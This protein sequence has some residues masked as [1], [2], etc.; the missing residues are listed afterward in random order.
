MA[1]ASDP[2][3][4]LASVTELVAYDQVLTL[5]L[6]RAANSVIS[7]PREPVGNVHDAVLRMGAAQVLSFAV[8]AGT[9]PFLDGAVPSYGLSE[10]ALWR[11]SVAAAVA[12]ETLKSFD[13]ALPAD[14]FTA[15][16]LH[17]VG[18]LV[19]DRFINSQTLGYIREAELTGH[20]SRADAELE[21]LNVQHAELGGVIAQHW[22]LP[23]SV[24]AGIAYHHHPAQSR[25]TIADFTWLANQLAKQIEAGVDGRKFAVA[26]DPGV[27]ERLGLTQSDLEKFGPRAAARYAEIAPWYLEI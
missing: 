25:E 3:C 24:V 14:T 11:H 26:L 16:L 8:A 22:N 27:A 6:L 15:A 18:K 20:L 9:R 7:A 10:G 13:L 12:V 19:L 21:L 4:D 5:K 23:P 17:D 1:L 2:S